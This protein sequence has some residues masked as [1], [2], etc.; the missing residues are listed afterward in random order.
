[1]TDSPDALAFWQALPEP[2]RT[3]ADALAVLCEPLAFPIWPDLY[4]ALG[5]AKKGPAAREAVRALRQTLQP[6][7]RP[8]ST[9]S[10]VPPMLD[11]VLSELR[12]R[13]LGRDPQAL[14]AFAA[15]VFRIVPAMIPPPL[16]GLA[17]NPA[18]ILQIIEQIRAGGGVRRDLRLAVHCNDGEALLRITGQ[19][20]E[21]DPDRWFVERPLLQIVQCAYDADW[22]YGREARVRWALLEDWFG[23]RVGDLE[24]AGEAQVMLD[25]CLRERPDG[26]ER[27]L[28]QELAIWRGAPLP[29]PALP[30]FRACRV[31]L[32]EGAAA[33]LPLFDEALAQRR[34]QLQDPQATL[35]GLPAFLYVGAQLAVR[36]A[37]AALELRERMGQ[38]GMNAAPTAG[39]ML[40]TALLALA[41]EVRYPSVALPEEPD[42]SCL[43]DALLRRWLGIAPVAGEAGMLETIAARATAA[44]YGWI[45][46]EARAVLAALRGEPAQSTL[47]TAITPLPVWQRALHRLSTVASAEPPDRVRLAWGIDRPGGR[48]RLELREQKPAARGGWTPGRQVDPQRYAMRS[49][50]ATLP[51]EDRAVFDRTGDALGLW[52]DEDNVRLLGALAGHPRVYWIGK[53]G[54]WLELVEVPPRLALRPDRSTAEGGWLLELLP[55][56]RK[57]GALWQMTRVKNTTRLE[58]TRYTPE[59]QHLGHILDN[60]RLRVPEAG[61]AELARTLQALD[62]VLP[63]AAALDAVLGDDDV[64]PGDSTPCLLL[65]PAGD[66]LRAQLCVEPLA[67]LARQRCGE[68]P[69]VLLGERSGR[70]L[71]IRRDAAAEQ[72]ARAALLDACPTLAGLD[73][74]DTLLLPEPQ[75]ALDLL[76]ELRVLDAAAATATAEVEPG[77][78]AAVRVV[79]PH[80]ESLRLRKVLHVQDLSLSLSGEGAWLQ[81]GGSVA[82]DE[83]RVLALSALAAAAAQGRYVALGNGEFVQ[84]DAALRRRLAD[85][86]AL[87]E[88]ARGAELRV[89]V[90]ALALVEDIAAEAGSVG[91]QAGWLARAGRLAE[92]RA[93]QAPLPTTLQAELRDYQIEGYRWLMRLAHWGAGACLADDMGLGKT[94]QT[95]AMLLARADGGPALVVAPTSVC[96]NWLAEAGRF[97]PSLALHDYSGSER[98]GRLDGLA[99][100]DVL[101]CSW[102]LLARDAEALAARPWHSVVLDEAQ[103]MK[104]AQTQRA[105]AACALEADFRVALSGTPVENRAAELWSLMRFLNPGLLGSR[106]RYTERYAT[107]IE[108]DRDAEVRARLRRLLAPFLLRRLK[109]Q[110]LDELP[111][112]TEIVRSVELSDGERALYEALR[113]EALTRAVGDASGEGERRMRLFADLMRLRRACCHPQL[114]VP[115]SDLPSAKLAAFAEI[116]GELRENRHRALVFS[117]F[118]DHLAHV[119]AWL[120]AEGIAYAYLDGSTPAPERSRQVAAFQG[121]HGD[122]FLISLRAGGTGLNLTAADYVI[123]LDPWWNPAVED[124]ATDRAHRLGQTR[125]VTVYRLVAR[126]TLEE[127]IV[128]L[129]RHKRDLAESLLADAGDSRLLSAEDLMALLREE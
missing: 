56:P 77:R 97:A 28:A 34:A 49:V 44:G 21:R 84:L 95:L 90:A 94:V 117:Q 38:C 43:F 91:T 35:Y 55:A 48:L 85:L 16:P 82:V 4:A 22:L 107:P 53:P 52:R 5:C 23:A 111:P 78:V 73:A 110:V 57:P 81:I 25:R 72:A 63:S 27:Q 115:G 40:E 39:T 15:Q 33:A 75:A 50:Y 70:P 32:D 46:A 80:G 123:H 45:A 37:G 68:G 58:F 47:T 96:A 76:A 93:L 92:A 118:V 11:A 51:P 74:D 87:A 61:R 102:A 103:A 17:Q 108:R 79:W 86:G 42:L 8:L 83:K 99:A 41:D 121:G 10:A 128:E 112:R 69:S 88:P 18:E 13:Q 127:R 31:F 89:P 19:M 105:R 101:V 54:E 67:G 6:L 2:A 113:R 126:D 12:M 122:L 20:L 59:Q 71:R 106:E 14:A 60:G 36:G 120:A 124:Q 104:N 98:A 9:R 3:F 116:V 24:D 119:R 129:H 100:G 64:Q 26:F 29:E 66:G 114:V 30:A 109:S 125:P 7:L 1:M 65:A 62:R